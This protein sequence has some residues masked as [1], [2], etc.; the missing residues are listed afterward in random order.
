[1]LSDRINS[2]SESQTLSMAAKAREMQSQGIEVIKLN[3]GEPDFQTPNHIKE[4][5]KKAID[6]GF[7][8]YPPVSGYSELRQGIADKLK[9]DNGLDYLPTEIVVSGGAKQS[10]ANVMFSILNPKDEVI[11]FAPY[12]ATYFEQVKMAEGVPVIISGNIENNF[13]VTADQLKAAITPKT[14]VVLFSSPCNPSGSVFTK[15]EL[16]AIAPSSS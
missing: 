13:K 6:D 8:F 3:L 16:K 11:I 7:T 14:K 4:A 12:W 1:M 5:A 9:R 10:L 15:Q 2:F